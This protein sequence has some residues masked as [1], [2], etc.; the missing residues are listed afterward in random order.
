MF[1]LITEIMYNPSSSEAPPAKTEW[2]ELFN[3]GKTPVDLGGW[4]LADEDGR[5][6]PLPPDSTIDPG[7]AVV[8]IPGNQSVEAFRAAWGEGFDVLALEGW[9]RPGLSGLANQ[10]SDRNEVLTL[11]RP[12]DTIVDEVNYDDDEP[13]DSDW[14][15]DWPHGPSIYLLPGQIDPT[16]NDEGAAW[17]RSAV[18]VYGGRAAKATEQYDSRDIGSP[19]VVV[20]DET[21]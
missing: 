11:R 18:E 20:V 7:E 12:D 5:T 13:E 15:G 8:L 6:A 14:P 17:N 1:I 19:G 2:V 21:K 3:P 16:S 10:P 4:Y 9:D